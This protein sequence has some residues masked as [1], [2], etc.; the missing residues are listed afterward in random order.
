VSASRTLLAK[1]N[2]RKPL[3]KHSLQA[4]AANHEAVRIGR[5]GLV[6]YVHFE[7]GDSDTLVIA[8]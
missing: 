2:K 8:T 6:G 5:V 3:T 1:P 4:D 7:P